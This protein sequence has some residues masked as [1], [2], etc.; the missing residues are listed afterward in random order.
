MQ[1]SFKHTFN[2]SFEEKTTTT[3]TTNHQEDVE[4]SRS[5]KYVVPG[6]GS[7]PRSFKYPDKLTHVQ[8]FRELL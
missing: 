7:D 3:T 6:D 2:F 1:T 8:G 5:Q 4:E